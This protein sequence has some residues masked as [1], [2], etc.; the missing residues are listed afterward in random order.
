MPCEQVILEPGPS[1][2]AIY[3]GWLAYPG[4][5]ARREEFIR[6]AT[7]G[8][9]KGLVRSGYPRKRVPHE[10]LPYKNEKILGVVNK[11]LYRIE[12]RRLR[13]AWMAIGIIENTATEITGVNT[14]A[15]AVAER[16]ADKGKNFEESNIIK[17]VWSES[18]PVLHLALALPVKWSLMWS[19]KVLARLLGLPESKVFSD[20]RPWLDARYAR[21]LGLPEPDSFPTESAP[22]ASLMGNGAWVFQSLFLAEVARHYVVESFPD[23]IREPDTVQLVPSDAWGAARTETYSPPRGASKKSIS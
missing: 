11:G 22:L 7:A 10:L 12:T 23:T 5:K 15:A 1:S 13:A 3:L 19:R 18:K 21:T 2:A 16:F 9:A 6:A 20:Y 4:D 8:V 17:R 14:A